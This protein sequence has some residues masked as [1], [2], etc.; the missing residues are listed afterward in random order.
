MSRDLRCLLVTHS[1]SGGGAERFAATL[2]RRLPRS[3]FDPGLALAVDRRDYE[4][5][6]DVTVES[7][8]YRSLLSLPR[9]IGRLRRRIRAFRPHLILSNVL[10][11]NCLV[12]A[13]LIGLEHRPGWIA[14]VGLAPEVGE[15]LFQRLWFRL[16]YPGVDF[17]VANSEGMVREIRKRYPRVTERIR[18][19]PNPTDFVRLEEAAARPLDFPFPGDGPKLVALGRLVPQ[20]RPDLAIEALAS[21]ED[22]SVH[23]LWAGSGPLETATRR[24]A[25]ISGVGDRLILPGFLSNPFPI[26]RRAD[27]FLLTSDFEGLPNALI[28][29]QGLGVPAVATR[30]RYG[31]EEIVDH[32]RTGLL[33]PPGDLEALVAALESL[34]GDSERLGRMA[35]A[36]A[37][38]ARE[39]YGLET[40][41]PRW[42]GLLREAVDAES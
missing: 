29:A 37:R 40:V 22:P 6:E 8:G 36:A 21:L 24:R 15:P 30:C 25:E 1:L 13:A 38:R 20:K 23:L 27:L 14:R 7:L 26:L 34:L 32:G 33:V 10:S 16:V 17:L 39:R 9:A 12:G 41:L 31:P 5:P 18:S 4:V 2:A 11:T 42:E 35:R 3:R 28:E 19:L